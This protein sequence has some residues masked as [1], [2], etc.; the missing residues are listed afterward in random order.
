MSARMSRKP[1]AAPIRRRR[2]VSDDFPRSGTAAGW[3]TP[4]L[5]SKGHYFV[6]GVSL[7][8]AWTYY[9]PLETGTPCPDSDCLGCQR[10]AAR[11]DRT[12][13]PSATGTVH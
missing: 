1:A 5:A 12:P 6:G 11:R 9:G 13:V 10:A 7:C 2:A 3:A 8:R 4:L